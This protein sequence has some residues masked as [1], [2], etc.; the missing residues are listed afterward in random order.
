MIDMIIITNG[1]GKI[2]LKNSGKFKQKWQKKCY[3]I[4][5]FMRVAVYEYS[6]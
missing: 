3:K 5:W 2:M 6:D 1:T 4:N